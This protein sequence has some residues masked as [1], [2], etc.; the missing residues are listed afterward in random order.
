MHTGVSYCIRELHS[1]VNFWFCDL[2][3]CY[4]HKLGLFKRCNSLFFFDFMKIGLSLSG[5]EQALWKGG[6]G[7]L[8][9]TGNEVKHV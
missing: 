2:L 8:R 9:A 4:L 7:G 5:K 3:L 1:S 6:G